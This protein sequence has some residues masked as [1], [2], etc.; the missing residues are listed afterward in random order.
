MTVET[1]IL[2][3]SNPPRHAI[4][5]YTTDGRASVSIGADKDEFHTSVVWQ[6][7]TLIFDVEEQEK[8]LTLKSKEIWLL[9]DDGGSLKRIRNDLDGS[10][11]RILIYQRVTP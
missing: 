4:Q 7:K 8:G 5:S 10:E 11:Q 1:T 2:R 3:G 6:G 9:I